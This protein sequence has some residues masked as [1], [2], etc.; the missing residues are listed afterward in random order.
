MSEIHL[1]VVVI[2]CLLAAQT[3]LGK[4]NVVV[5]FIAGRHNKRFIHTNF[6]NCLSLLYF[7]KHYLTFKNIYQIQSPSILHKN[8]SI[9]TNFK[10]STTIFARHH[11]PALAC[12]QIRKFQ[13][14][15]RVIRSLCCCSVHDYS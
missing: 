3:C 11:A 15:I 12:M 14:V 8:F 2:G 1:L 6:H 5:V 9:N 7:T 4:R 13:S 10:V